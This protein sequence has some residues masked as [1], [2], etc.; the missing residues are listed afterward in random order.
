MIDFSDEDPLAQFQALYKE[1]SV[2]DPKLV[3]KHS[4]ILANKL[5]SEEARVAYEANKDAFPKEFGPLIPI[6]AKYGMGLKELLE[7]LRTIS[8]QKKKQNPVQEVYN[9]VR[10]AEDG[11]T[12]WR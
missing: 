6:S 12:R 10:E 2:Y 11:V 9:P 1:L 3:G 8:D 5:D 4:V 7:G